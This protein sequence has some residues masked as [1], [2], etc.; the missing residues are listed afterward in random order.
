MEIGPIPGI[1][2]V[3]AVRTLERESVHAL[4][5]TLEAAVRTGDDTYSGSGEAP[6]R[7]LESDEDGPVEEAAGERRTGRDR[8][9]DGAVSGGHVDV[10][11]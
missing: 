7:G 2:A 5:E 9:L 10:M 11:A 8:R 4:D 6:E 1:R 3:R